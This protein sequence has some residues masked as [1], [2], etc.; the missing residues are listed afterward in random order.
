MK[1][2]TITLIKEMIVTIQHKKIVLCKN[3]M[4]N[5]HNLNSLDYLI[6]VF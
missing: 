6:N 5:K 2:K 4:Y 3:T 1:G